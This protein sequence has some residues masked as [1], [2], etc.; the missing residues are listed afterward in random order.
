MGFSYSYASIAVELLDKNTNCVSKCM[1]VKFPT[2]GVE[3]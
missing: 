3:F 2:I 1:K